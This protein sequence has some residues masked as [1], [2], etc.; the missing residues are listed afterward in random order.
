MSNSLAVAMVT[1][2]LDQTLSEALAGGIAGG[3]ENASVSTLRPDMLADADGDARGINVFLYQV[4]PN[5]AWTGADLPTRR[6]GGELLTRP[7]QALDLHYLLTFSGDESALEPQRLLGLAVS[8]LVA[9]PVLSRELVRAAIT[10]AVRE[11][12]TTWQQYSDL[13]AQIDVVRFTLLSLSLEELSQ[14]WSTF[15]Q[16]PYRLS[17]AY[18]ATVVLLDTDL[19]PE[20]ALPV[21]SRLID[22]S[23]FHVPSITRVVAASAPTDPVT[24]GTMVRIEGQ[25]LRGGF[26]TRVRFAGV[27]VTPPASQ[28][29][30]TAITVVLPPGV[31]AGVQGVQ[32][33]HPRMVGDPPEERADAESDV[34]PL[35]VRPVVDGPVTTGPGAAAEIV[36]VTVPLDPPVGKRQRVA[37][38]LNELGP[39]AGQA[40]RAYRFV[41][42]PFDPEG[43]DTLDEVTVPVRGVKAGDYLVRV[44]VGGAES[45]LGVAADGRYDRPKV[46]IP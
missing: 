28:V 11:D 46:T 40:A 34:A 13:A 1:A 21:R 4:V 39:A 18:Q 37:L 14:L 22:V 32:V 26:V 7:Q 16:A 20:P 35:I 5:G 30:D 10:H 15:F 25:Q 3:V 6:P 2:A 44:Q 36:D 12:P 27:E 23:P 8:T 19:A 41:A 38:A 24:P 43:P 45:V 31:P 17:V 29:T 9:R 42:A 33:L